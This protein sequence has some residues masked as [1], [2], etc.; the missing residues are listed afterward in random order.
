MSQDGTANIERVISMLLGGNYVCNGDGDIQEEGKTSRST[1]S[2]PRGRGR[3]SRSNGETEI[4]YSRAFAL[5]GEDAL[6]TPRRGIGNGKSKSTP[7]GVTF[8]GAEQDTDTENEAASHSNAAAALRASLRRLVVNDHDYPRPP[9]EMSGAEVST[10][11]PGLRSKLRL[12]LKKADEARGGGKWRGVGGSVD[13]ETVRRAMAACG[14]PLDGDQL[15]QLE[16]KLDQGG[17]GRLK[18]EVKAYIFE[19]LYILNLIVVYRLCIFTPT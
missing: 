15:W 19:I 11:G 18:V 13:R 3:D 5:P 7:K 6:T 1:R 16:T 17:T 2:H 4:S 14:A 12:A 10:A 9:G 8:Q